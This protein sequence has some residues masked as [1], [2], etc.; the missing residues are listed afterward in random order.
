M[1]FLMG[2]SRGLSQRRDYPWFAEVLLPPGIAVLLLTLETRAFENWMSSLPFAKP[3]VQC[4]E[5]TMRRDWY[6]SCVNTFPSR[7]AR[8]FGRPRFFTT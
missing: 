5:P 1:V 7:I 8:S 3:L 2:L 6:R 4:S